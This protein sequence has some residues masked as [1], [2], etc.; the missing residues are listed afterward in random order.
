[1]LGNIWGWIISLSTFETIEL[2]VGTVMGVL[3]L[4]YWI[5]GLL[6]GVAPRS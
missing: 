2:V 6:I 1:M 5:A 3:T 4:Y